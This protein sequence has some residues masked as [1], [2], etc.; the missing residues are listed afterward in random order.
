MIFPSGVRSSVSWTDF[1]FLTGVGVSGGGMSGLAGGAAPPAGLIGAGASGTGAEMAFSLHSCSILFDELL[2]YFCKSGPVDIFHCEQKECC[3]I[4]G[5]SGIGFCGCG[6]P[7]F[8][9]NSREIF[10]A[11]HCAFISSAPPGHCF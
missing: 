2:P 10:L 11:E 5:L 6:S 8:L 4:E 3:T 1:F 7:S 9:E